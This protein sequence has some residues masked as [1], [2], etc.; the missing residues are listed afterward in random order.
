[1]KKSKINLYLLST[2]QNI[3]HHV[4]VLGQTDKTT[5][6]SQNRL[7]YDNNNSTG[8]EKK[9]FSCILQEIKYLVVHIAS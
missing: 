7:S 4:L 1:M 5:Y 6:S 3:Q 8:W 2:C 9:Y